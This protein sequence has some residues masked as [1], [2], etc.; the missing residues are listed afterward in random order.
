MTLIGFQ[1]VLWLMKTR[2]L[3]EVKLVPW[4]YRPFFHCRLSEQYRLTNCIG[5]TSPDAAAV[6]TRAQTAF[7]DKPFVSFILQ[8]VPKE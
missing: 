3:L 2:I 5:S 6:S 8:H 1:E 7:Y 4:C